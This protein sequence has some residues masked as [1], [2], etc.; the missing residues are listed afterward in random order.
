[1]NKIDRDAEWHCWDM[2]EGGDMRSNKE[3]EKDASWKALHDQI[4]KMPRQEFRKEKDRLTD[5]R[6]AAKAYVDGYD[7][8]ES[9]KNMKKVIRLTESDLHKI[10]KESA[11]K[12]IREGYYGDDL[13]P[14]VI[15]A[16]WSKVGGKN[17]DTDTTQPKRELVYNPHYGP[18][19]S[20]TGGKF[21][22]PDGELIEIEGIGEEVANLVQLMRQ[23][24]GDSNRLM[25]SD[26]KIVMSPTGRKLDKLKEILND[27]YEKLWYL[28][29]KVEGPSYR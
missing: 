7:F 29:E 19:D 3:I 2:F 8:N 10:I 21:K 5:K 26:K 28:N 24:Y 17:A 6:T 11:K 9:K 22:L 4:P 25:N 14:D 20:L 12:I 18:A 15:A 1:M 27:C 23:I 16:L 13:P